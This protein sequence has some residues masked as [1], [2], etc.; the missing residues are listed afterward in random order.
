MR[1]LKIRRIPSV[2]IF[3]LKIFGHT[4]RS[5]EEIADKVNIVHVVIEILL[6]G[7]KIVE[8][9]TRVVEVA[10]VR[11]GE[12]LRVQ[13]VR[14]DLQVKVLSL[15]ALVEKLTLDDKGLLKVLFLQTVAE[16][17]PLR[18]QGLKFLVTRRVLFLLCLDS[19]ILYCLVLS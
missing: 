16:L 10:N 4:F 6:C 7:L 17:V 3:L 8:L 18:L 12:A 11:E 2:R 1:G 13:L 19:L 14:V 15:R 5:R 9:L